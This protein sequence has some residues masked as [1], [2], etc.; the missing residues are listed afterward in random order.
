MLSISIQSDLSWQRHFA[1]VQPG[2]SWPGAPHGSPHASPCTAF[3]Y[4]WDTAVD[5]CVV[6]VIVN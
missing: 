6:G 1:Q 5:V 3:S 2:V 4:S